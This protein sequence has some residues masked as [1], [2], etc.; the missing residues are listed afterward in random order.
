MDIYSVLASKPHNPHYLYRYI[1]FIRQCQL[2]NIDYVGYTEK[3]H[4]CPKAKDMFY[5][6]KSF[7]KHP[8]NIVVLTPRQHFIA[9][10]LLWK[11]FYKSKSQ[12][13][14][15]NLM[16]NNDEIKN[17]KLYDEMRRNFHALI[18]SNAAKP[19]FHLKGLNNS[20]HKRI[21][22][23]T[24]VFLSAEFRKE[25]SERMKNNN[26]MSLLRTNKGSFK[27]GHK[28][29]ITKERNEKI[30][31][32]KIGRNNPNYGNKDSWNSANVKSKCKYCSIV[33]TAGNIKRWH[34]DNCKNKDS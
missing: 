14:A 28:P 12:I 16:K 6:F 1:T 26:P 2:K 27:K 9:H 4:I 22:D 18:K 29:V 25:S 34:D 21:E 20:C 7:S 15:L 24:H 3:H 5:E 8:W 30:S 19:D 33:T 17:S 32:S 13:I 31:K 23:G 11:A 10:L